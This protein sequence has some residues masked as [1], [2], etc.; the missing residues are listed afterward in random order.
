MTR[1]LRCKVVTIWCT[2][3]RIHCLQ[4]ITARPY[5]FTRG[6]CTMCMPCHTHSLS[7]S[8]HPLCCTDARDVFNRSLLHLACEE[9]QVA[10][11]EY[12]IEKAN[13]DVGEWTEIDSSV[14]CN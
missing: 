4:S 14:V 9:G 5:V 2:V 6:D 13:C 1:Q 12:L 11:V 3:S 8:L 7:D 10:A